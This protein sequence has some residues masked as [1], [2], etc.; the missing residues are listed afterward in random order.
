[1]D[2]VNVQVAYGSEDTAQRISDDRYGEYDD[3]ARALDTH[4]A[5]ADLATTAADHVFQGWDSGRKIT[6]SQSHG[7]CR[8]RQMPSSTDEL[9][10]MAERCHF[11]LDAVEERLNEPRLRGMSLCDGDRPAYLNPAEPSK[12]RPTLHQTRTW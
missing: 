10:M 11:I 9:T 1:M 3:R 8:S 5:S 2:H 6:R 4:G 12:V 7:V